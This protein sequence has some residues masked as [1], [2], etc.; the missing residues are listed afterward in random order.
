VTDAGHFGRHQQGGRIKSS[1]KTKGTKD[2]GRKKKKKVKDT[3]AK[4]KGTGGPTRPYLT[5]RFLQDNARSCVGPD[6]IEAAGAGN[7]VSKS[8]QDT[9]KIMDEEEG[10]GGCNRGDCIRRQNRA[11]PPKREGAKGNYQ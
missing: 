5:K 10:Q 9:R 7:L 3:H 8:M 2:G 6:Q 4:K 11:G 1:I